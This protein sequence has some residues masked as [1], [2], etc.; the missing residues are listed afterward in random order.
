MSAPK[1]VQIFKLRTVNEGHFVLG[2]YDTV[3]GIHLVAAPKG[4]LPGNLR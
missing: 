1:A 3:F 2:Y 4:L